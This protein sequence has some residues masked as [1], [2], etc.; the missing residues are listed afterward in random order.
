MEVI[1]IEGNIYLKD[2]DR[3]IE[4]YSLTEEINFSKLV[5]YLLGMNLSNRVELVNNLEDLSEDEGNLINLIDRIIIAYNE[6]VDNLKEFN[7]LY[8]K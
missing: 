3:V 8:N 6:R 4:S 1:R 2:K 5:E 7:Q